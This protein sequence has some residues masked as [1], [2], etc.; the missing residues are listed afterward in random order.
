VKKGEGI[1]YLPGEKREGGGGGT[2]PPTTIR[3]NL[4]GAQNVRLARK[5]KE[6]KKRNPREAVGKVRIKRPNEETA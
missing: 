2:Q 1:P 6:T 3:R 5:T 4:G